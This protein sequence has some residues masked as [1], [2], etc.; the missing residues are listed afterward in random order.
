M[1]SQRK[2]VSFGVLLIKKFKLPKKKEHR[3]ALVMG[4]HHTFWQTHECMERREHK[5]LSKRTHALLA[6]GRAAEL[7]VA[8]E[9]YMMEPVKP[10]RPPPPA[11][12]RSRSVESEKSK[13]GQVAPAQGQRSVDD[14]EA[15]TSNMC[16][17]D[18]ASIASASLPNDALYLQPNF[19]HADDDMGED[20]EAE[21]EGEVVLGHASSFDSTFDGEVEPVKLNSK[22]T[23][24]QAGAPRSNS[25]DK[26]ISDAAEMHAE[27]AKGHGHLHGDDAG[28]QDLSLDGRM[29]TSQGNFLRHHHC[30]SGTGKRGVEP[31]T[32]ANRGRFHATTT[33]HIPASPSRVH[34]LARDRQAR[35]SHHQASCASAVLV[36]SVFFAF[37][38][39]VRFI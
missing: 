16:P 19:Q 31:R 12:P 2:S 1:E 18:R 17:M 14:Q 36:Q 5:N 8:V 26:E 34:L 10:R 39:I 15:T 9:E 32:A 37:S 33:W 13:V 25:P 30:G 28:N 4:E 7:R 3:N 22:A 21:E 35:L 38:C 27:G 6:L 20:S 23:E 24:D 11:R 29:S